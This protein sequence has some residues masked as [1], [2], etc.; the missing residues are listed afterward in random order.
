VC[1]RGTTARRGRPLAL[2]TLE[3]EVHNFRKAY[4]SLLTDSALI[5]LASRLQAAFR[6]SDV[7]A[8][9]GDGRFAVLLMV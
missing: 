2:L 5:E 8:R 3:L 1:T 7:V 9:T 4:G 6:D